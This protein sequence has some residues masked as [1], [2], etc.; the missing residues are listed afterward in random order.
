MSELLHDRRLEKKSG[1]TGRCRRFMG[2]RDGNAANLCNAANLFASQRG[3]SYDEI[4]RR[5]RALAS[6]RIALR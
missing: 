4:K 1:K 6:S 2:G 5:S 3:E